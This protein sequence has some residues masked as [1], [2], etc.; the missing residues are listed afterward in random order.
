MC[1]NSK[2]EQVIAYFLKLQ[3]AKTNLKKKP[4]LKMTYC[5]ST[6]LK[7]YHTIHTDPPQY[8]AHSGVHAQV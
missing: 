7:V 8:V 2:T 6:T 1:K 5:K 3:L 4:S